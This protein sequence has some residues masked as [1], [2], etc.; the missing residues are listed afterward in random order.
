[1]FL[2][3]VKKLYFE[4]LPLFAKSTTSISTFIGVCNELYNKKKSP[5]EQVMNIIGLSTLGLTIGIMY[6]V[7]FPLLGYYVSNEN[8]KLPITIIS[9]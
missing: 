5:A 2:H 1:M 6:P 9:K 7:S 4:Y 3:S 8:N